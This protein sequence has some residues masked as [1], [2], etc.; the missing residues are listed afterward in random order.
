MRPTA[1]SAPERSELI[2][3]LLASGA[4]AA[5]PEETNPFYVVAARAFD[6]KPLDEELCRALRAAGHAPSTPG[7]NGDTAMDL[8]RQGVESMRA[9][10][11]SMHQN[12]TTKK[13][14]DEIEEKWTRIF[15]RLESADL[16]AEVDRASRSAAE[17]S[18]GKEKRQSKNEKTGK[19]SPPPRNARR[20]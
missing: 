11:G 9:S 19:K 17:S 18:P 6:K 13:A 3:Q 1:L 2:S 16:M 8:A 7:L 15:C 14:L 12:A 20:I 4:P 10:L 5:G